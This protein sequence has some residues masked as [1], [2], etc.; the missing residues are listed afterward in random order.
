MTIKIYHNPRCSKSRETL[1]LLRDHDIEPEIIEYLKSGIQAEKLKEII[2]L[3]KEPIIELIRTGDAAFKEK[4][5][6]TASLN[7]ALIIELITKNPI[8][9][10]RPIVC[11][12]ITASITRPPEKVLELI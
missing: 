6:N 9:L 12:E 1:N 4:N 5:I 8:L 3:L 2:S 7:E 11:T 10:Q